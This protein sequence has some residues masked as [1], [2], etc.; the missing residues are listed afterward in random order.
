MR[1]LR[2]SSTL[3]EQALWPFVVLTRNV[4][5]V[6]AR[7]FPLEGTLVLGQRGPGPRAVLRTVK[8][9]S[10]RYGIA[11]TGEGFFVSLGWTGAIFTCVCAHVV[12]ASR[13]PRERAG[14]CS[15]RG[16]SSWACAGAAS[17][18][19]PRLRELSPVVP[20]PRTSG[21]VWDHP[22]ASHTCGS[23][24]PCRSSRRRRAMPA[25]RPSCPACRSPMTDRC[26]R[27]RQR[28]LHSASTGSKCGHGSGAHL[29]Q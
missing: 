8:N 5:L 14:A 24:S 25:S 2:V 7:D 28:C 9:P 26:C 27:S 20:S 1:L 4:K 13:P 16:V 6:H 29:A 23:R 18:R 15:G 10:L 19:S 22:M 17:P 12:D 21:L 11:G 3:S